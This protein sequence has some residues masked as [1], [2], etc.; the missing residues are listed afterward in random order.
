MRQCFADWDWGGFFLFRGTLLERYIEKELGYPCD[1]TEFDLDPGRAL[2]E[3]RDVVIWNNDPYPKIPLAKIRRFRMEWDPA[4][5]KQ[6]PRKL[7]LLEVELDELTL[8]RLDGNQ[9]NI[10][11]FV[12]AIIKAWGA[13]STGPRPEGSQASGLLIDECWLF[14]DTLIALDQEVKGGKRMEVLVEYEDY[15]RNVTRIRQI[16]D[17]AIKIAKDEVN[18]FYFFNYFGDALRALIRE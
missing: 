18:G 12:E 13:E 4:F 11:E 1:V 17:P 10:L 9:F 16:T 3:L 8:V 15:Q 7:R 14:L 5:S 6:F 2:I